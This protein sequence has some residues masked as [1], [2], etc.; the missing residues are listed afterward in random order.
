MV[1]SPAQGEGKGAIC[2]DLGRALAK[3]GKSPLILDCD[4]RKGSVHELF[5]MDN[6]R[7]MVDVLAGT[8]RL[9]EVWEEPAKGLKVI[10]TGPIPRDPE[11]LLD[12]RR[13][14][15]VITSVREE[16]FDYILVH[17]PSVGSISDPS[18]LLTHEGEVLLVLAAR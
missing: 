7:G 10:S 2:A 5:G 12:P 13:L 11:D 8:H 14:S 1:A 6:A 4:F 16:E 9:Q 15:Q 3:A 17:S 18:L